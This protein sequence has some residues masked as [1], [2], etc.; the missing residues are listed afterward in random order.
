MGKIRC[1]DIMSRDLITVEFGIKLEGAWTLLRFHKVKT[2][3]VISR[4]RRV[5]GILTPVDFLK[6][7]NLKTN[8]GF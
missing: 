5:I 2:L 6:R 4:A 1:T 3:P 7:A 8:E